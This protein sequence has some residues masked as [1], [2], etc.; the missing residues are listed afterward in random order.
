[1][2]DDIVL[3][4]SDSLST[5]LGRLK[6]DQDHT[7]KIVN[8]PPEI[9]LLSK[10]MMVLCELSSLRWSDPLIYVLERQ[11]ISRSSVRIKRKWIRMAASLH[12]CNSLF[13]LVLTSTGDKQTIEAFGAVPA[14]ASLLY[15]TIT[16]GD[17]A[18]RDDPYLMLPR[19]MITTD[20][21]AFRLIFSP[22]DDEGITAEDNRRTWSVVQALLPP[23]L[24]TLIRVLDE[25]ATFSID[26]VAKQ[27]QE[28]IKAMLDKNFLAVFEM[29]DK[30]TDRRQVLL[31]YFV[32]LNSIIAAL[33]TAGGE[34]ERRVRETW[35]DFETSV[36]M[37][38]IS[39][40]IY[41]D[42][43]T[44]KI[45]CSGFLDDIGVHSVH[46]S[47]ITD[48]L[49]TA[50]A[51]EDMAMF[52]G[53]PLDINR[54]YLI[55]QGAARCADLLGGVEFVVERGHLWMSRLGLMKVIRKQV[56]EN[57]ART[58]SKCIDQYGGRPVESLYGADPVF[59]VLLTA[60]QD[61]V[62]SALLRPTTNRIRRPDGLTLP[63][64]E[65]LADP[66]SAV[67][68]CV[69]NSI[70][71]FRVEKRLEH[72]SRVKLFQLLASMGYSI[73]DV[74]VFIERTVDPGDSKRLS[75]YKKSAAV[76]F[77]TLGRRQ[78]SCASLLTSKFDMGSSDNKSRGCPFQKATKQELYE[79]L[80]VSGLSTDDDVTE[81]RSILNQAEHK[82]PKVAC[83]I[84]GK[85]I[86]KH[87]RAAAAAA[88]ASA[89]ASSSEGFP[90]DSPAERF[91]YVLRAQQIG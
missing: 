17:E 26:E 76:E 35:V 62:K 67:P 10:T 58:L 89:P 80:Q 28:Y 45:L 18:N 29:R 25:H 41:D 65:D 50:E 71:S 38:M 22:N 86:A 81:M 2:G 39:P 42:E 14:L 13:F 16:K 19:S 74:Q 48:Y 44:D 4:V 82:H 32:V 37:R 90:F 52:S 55:P 72:F 73:D 53:C 36:R 11:D 12:P 47:R 33:C 34:V 40:C 88:G 51:I 7:P 46:A 61:H 43:S 56:A 66:L 85:A 64:I 63:D 20:R 79:L 59:L 15:C 83:L 9:R 77:N 27:V 54:C 24:N 87:T 68:L 3:D 70:G 78:L 8:E 23:D 91:H 84:H 6:N 1:M 60:F 21:A 31:S 30:A 75:E 57:L 69:F 49:V 5:L